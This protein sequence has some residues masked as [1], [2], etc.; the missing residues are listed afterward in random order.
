M[1]ILKTIY[2]QHLNGSNNNITLAADGKVGI[3]TSTPL[4]KIHISEANT[5]VYPAI[6]LENTVSSGLTP[7]VS[8][9]WT[10]GGTVKS[11]I[12]SN[13]YGNDYMAFKVSSNIERMRINSDGYVTKPSQ[14]AFWVY[15]ASGSTAV[16]DTVVKY[17][18]IS[19]NIGSCYSSSTGR[20]TAP[21]A[22][23]YL[24]SFSG[25][26]DATSNRVMMRFQINGNDTTFASASAAAYSD[27]KATVIYTLNAGDYV[28][29]I[30]R[31]NNFYSNGNGVEFY[32]SGYLLG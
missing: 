23:R 25:M 13:V 8:I 31:T 11:S 32:F 4:S 22:G 3:G 1:S 28:N 9:N 18:G 17:T 30:A 15:Q 27:V 21:V 20:F 5:G 2:L 26:G 10:Q 29:V 24:F 7:G 16:V 14:P 19:Y 12:E 6:T